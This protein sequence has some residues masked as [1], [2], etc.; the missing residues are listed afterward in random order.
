MNYN[1][2]YVTD[3]TAK[4]SAVT[5]YGGVKFTSETTEYLNDATVYGETPNALDWT[6][7]K[8]IKSSRGGKPYADNLADFDLES[9]F[10]EQDY[11]NCVGNADCGK[12]D[13]KAANRTT[14]APDTYNVGVLGAKRTAA[15]ERRTL[16]LHAEVQDRHQL[17][18][19]E[20]PAD[21]RAGKATR[22]LPH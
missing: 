7:E 1:V 3:Q 21:G 19:A 18:R 22:R 10:V 2:K 12:F 5:T 13:Y 8:T 4:D 15:N 6:L 16:E 17:R 20:L 14:T 11:D 9:I